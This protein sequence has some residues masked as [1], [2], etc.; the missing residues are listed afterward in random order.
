MIYKSKT[1]NKI[2]FCNILIVLLCIASIVSYFLM[3]FW[4]V[5]ISYA[6]SAKTLETFLGDDNSNEN[7][8]G[9]A[10]PTSIILTEGE[11]GGNEEGGAEEG[12]NGEGGS[13]SSEG[14]INFEDLDFAEILGD[15]TYPLNLTLEIKTSHIFAAL[16]SDVSAMID[17]LIAQNVNT[18]VDQLNA[19]INDIVP[20][21][22][23]GVSKQVLYEQLHTQLEN[24]YQGEKEAEEIKQILNDCGVDDTYIDT[25]TDALID[26]IYA[27]DATV[28]SVADTVVTIVDDAFNKLSESELE[29]IE[30]L[31]EEDKNEIRQTVTEVLSEIA[32]EDGKL[33]ADEMLTRLLLQML[34]SEQSDNSGEG[35]EGG[36]VTPAVKLLS[37]SASDGEI[38]DEEKQDVTEELKA[39]IREMLVV[40]EATTEAIAQVFTGI[41]YFL[42]FEFFTWA[43]LIL[44]ILLKLGMKNNA[45]KVKLPIWFGWLPYLILCMLPN[46]LFGALTNPTPEL[47]EM[48]GDETLGL[49]S[50]LSVNCTSCS[51]ISFYCA[52]ALALFSIIYYGRLRRRMRKIARGKIVEEYGA[53]HTV[54]EYPIPVDNGYY[55]SPSVSALD[56]KAHTVLEIP[57]ETATAT[58]E[59]PTENANEPV[60]EIALENEEVSENKTLNTAE[61]AVEEKSENDQEN[62]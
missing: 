1:K 56:G 44:K 57:K 27:E 55:T 4:K 59:K 38:S 12:G 2:F 8:E 29:D 24:F 11:E 51:C 58:T 46:A 18:I 6:L 20:N 48:V 47:L 62:V 35:N 5:D 31:T 30:T 45:I 37:A 25:Q 54:V 23:K 16:N 32:T 7:G 41:S 28:D 17:D 22:V 9:G 53:K 60:Q 40:D 49:L 42:L 15:K 39:K 14:G 61:K 10:S 3:P 21:V 33:N 43:Y 19:F 36:E 34:N 26:A 13:S 52:C 50:G